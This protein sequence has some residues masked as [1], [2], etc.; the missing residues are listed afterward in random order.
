MCCFDKRVV[1]FSGIGQW[2]TCLCGCVRIRVRGDV[3]REEEDIEGDCGKICNVDGV[4]DVCTTC[5]CIGRC[6]VGKIGV[7]DSKEVVVECV[8]DTGG[9]RIARCV[10]LVCT[11]M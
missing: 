10:L 2:W 5:V 8:E 3:A 9:V 1:V 7:R 11:K 6:G 4:F